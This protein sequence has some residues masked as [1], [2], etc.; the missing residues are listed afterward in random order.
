MT[1]QI[2]IETTPNPEA[3]KFVA[4]QAIA[5]TTRS[6]STT[7]D[8]YSS[9]LAKKLFAFPW[10]KA[11][12]IGPNFVSVVKQE[13]VDWTVL[14]EPLSQLIQEHLERG[15]GVLFEEKTIEPAAV[16]A[17]ECD[18]SPLVQKIK[19]ILDT[20]IRPAVAMDGGDIVFQRYENGRVYLRM[21]GACSGCPS[22]TFTLKEG[23]E[24]RMKELLPEVTEV[25]S[26]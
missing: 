1:W 18:D 10:A 6:F 11:V 8:T 23:I 15:E 14:A 17:A 13:W 9:P 24:T 25:I 22:A 19:Q 26:V 20:E 12:L 2:R 4:N 21:Q 5:T 7:V 3:L 16:A